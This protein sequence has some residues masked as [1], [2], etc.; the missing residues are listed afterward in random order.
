MLVSFLWCSYMHEP[1][2][3][4]HNHVADIFFF[5]Y[6][7]EQRLTANLEFCRCEGKVARASTSGGGESG[8]WYGFAPAPGIWKQLPPPSAK[9]SSPQR[10]D[11]SHRTINCSPFHYPT[12][13]FLTDTVLSLSL[14][15]AIWRQDLKAISFIGSSSVLGIR[16]SS[17]LVL[18]LAYFQIRLIWRQDLFI[19]LILFIVSC[20]HEIIVRLTWFSFENLFHVPILIHSYM[21]QVD[22][23]SNLGKWRSSSFHFSSAAPKSSIIDN[24][25]VS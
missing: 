23:Q 11:L 3:R 14:S 16:S 17:V 18:L 7:Q 15:S 25:E 5:I 10:C 21:F 12:H 22:F 4:V 6:L 24:W 1:W 19:C 13:R 2:I 20:D 9:A 8:Q